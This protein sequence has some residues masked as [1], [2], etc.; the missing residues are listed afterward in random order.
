MT[1]TAS[2]PPLA[3]LGAQ[4]LVLGNRNC[5][6]AWQPVG[7]PRSVM[8]TRT[9]FRCPTRR[10]VKSADALPERVDRL[11]QRNKV[12]SEGYLNFTTVVGNENK[13][14]VKGNGN[15]TTVLGNQNRI[16]GKKYDKRCRRQQ[17]RHHGDRRRQQGHAQAQEGAGVKGDNNITTVVGND[18]KASANGNRNITSVFGNRSRARSDGDNKVSTAVGD[19]KKPSTGSTTTEL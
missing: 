13:M 1:T 11:R 8:T 18:S 17:Q 3:G 4:D 6:T 12:G 15:V 14:G 9:T 16:T 5:S 19:D 7:P 10:G 2:S